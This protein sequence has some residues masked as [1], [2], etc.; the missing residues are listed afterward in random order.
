MFDERH[1]EQ[2]WYVT[3]SWVEHL[4]DTRP[5]GMNIS[6]PRHCPEDDDGFEWTGFRMYDDDGILYYEGRMNQYCDGF[7]PL[8]DFGTPNAGCTMIK[9]RKKDGS[10]ELL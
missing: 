6:G 1:P 8:N 2:K 3:T 10:W 9:I 7:E 5:K 4:P